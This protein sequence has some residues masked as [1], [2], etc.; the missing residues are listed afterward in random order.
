MPTCFPTPSHDGLSG[1]RP[2]AEALAD[3]ERLRNEAVMPM[4]EST[5]SRALLEPLPPHVTALFCALTHN[6][7][8]ADRFFG[9]DAGTV[10][11]E[12]FFRPEN[13]ERIMRSAAAAAG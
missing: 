13:I 12:E 3:Y 2:F 1:R 4:Y 11:L 9:T 10:P 8:D 5:C 7:A 6:Q